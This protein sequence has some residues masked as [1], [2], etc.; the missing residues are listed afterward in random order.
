MCA[1]LKLEY[2]MQMAHYVQSNFHALQQV[3][4]YAAAA[5]LSL[6]IE[7]PG[8]NKLEALKEIAVFA[9]EHPLALFMTQGYRKLTEIIY[10]ILA[11]VDSV[12]QLISFTKVFRVVMQLKF[13]PQF[14][15]EIVN[16]T[17]DKYLDITA[18]K[19][20]DTEDQIEFLN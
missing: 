14:E 10:Q 4:D 1:V 12:D 17:V 7:K 18:Q 20:T 2:R 13:R 9:K 5:E 3:N 11:A 15:N 8:E 16:A 19:K 6:A